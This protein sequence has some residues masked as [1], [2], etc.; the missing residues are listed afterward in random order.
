MP[1]EGYCQRR[2]GRIDRLEA[3]HC[4]KA[5]SMSEDE[6]S[7]VNSGPGAK[8]GREPEAETKEDR[9]AAALRANLKRRK[10]QAR[11]RKADTLGQ[12]DPSS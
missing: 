5:R 10:A 12:D 7:G 8:K 11:G 6:K 1:H 9:R 2:T 4:V 3:S